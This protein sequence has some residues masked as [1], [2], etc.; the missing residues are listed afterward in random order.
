VSWLAVRFIMTLRC[1]GAMPKASESRLA[2]YAAAV[3][4]GGA[5]AKN[6]LVGMYQR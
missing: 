1:A 2:A 3:T 5:S 4:C 6:P